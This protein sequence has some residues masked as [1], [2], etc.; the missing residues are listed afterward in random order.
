MG[1]TMRRIYRLPM[2]E[3][4]QSGHFG[5]GRLG[6][7]VLAAAL[8]AACNNAAGLRG[9]VSCA[10]V[11]AD[12]DY[13]TAVPLCL[14]AARGGDAAGQY[15]L[16][17]LHEKG[18]G[19]DADPDA[20]LHWYA[21]A[22]GQGH[23]RSQVQLAR[24]YAAARQYDKARTFAQMAADQGDPDGFVMMGW[25]YA[26]GSQILQGGPNAQTDGDADDAAS[27][28]QWFLRAER[29]GV[30]EAD[31]GLGFLYANGIGVEQNEAT[32]IAH[33][34]AAS[35]GGSWLNRVQASQ[36]AAD[37]HEQRQNHAEAHRWHLHGAHLNDP[38]AQSRL[39]Q[40]YEHGQGIAQNPAMAYTWAAVAA[41]SS[42]KL[43]SATKYSQQMERLAANL[44][45]TDRRRAD[46]RATRIAKQAQTKESR[47]RTS[48]R[49]GGRP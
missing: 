41:K 36:M 12:A 4:G 3:R 32:A 17:W 47:I 8:L 6:A 5:A 40:I 15:H 14:A 37:L 10:G 1:K 21:K 24:L 45:A 46:R 49:N 42:A 30:P 29:A 27:A 23:A 2:Q 34:E 25:V 9:R 28:L 16:G 20:A 18:L 13:A 11:F 48:G 26:A 44:S 33:F 22:A 7:I 31:T 38:G 19:V 35:S 43:S 39:A